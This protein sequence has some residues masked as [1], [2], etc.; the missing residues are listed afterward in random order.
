MYKRQR[1]ACEAGIIPA[2]LGGNREVLDLG[3]AS[4]LFTKAQRIAMALRD[5]GCIAEGCN[6]P[7]HQCHAHHLDPWARG[8]PTNL[9]HG[10][11]LCGH[12][13]RRAHDPRY[14]VQRLGTGKLRFTRRT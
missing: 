6:R 2:V 5:G 9:D 14:T 7:P 11:L 1:L 10:G 13:H 8:G 3:R 4:R 12:H